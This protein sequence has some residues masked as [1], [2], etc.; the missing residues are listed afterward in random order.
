MVNGAIVVAGSR[1][2]RELAAVRQQRRDWGSGCMLLKELGEFGLIDRIARSLPAPPEDVLVGI[3]DDVA[4][5]GVSGTDYLLATCDSQ[6]ENVHFLRSAITPYR[7][8]RK[9]VAINV[10]DIASMG[11]DPSWALVSLV[12]PPDLPVDFVDELYRGSNDKVIL[13]IFDMR[14]QLVRKFEK[15]NV[16]QGFYTLYWDANDNGGQKIAKGMYFFKFSH[17]DKTDKGK[18]IILN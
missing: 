12:L 8:G 10:S 5:L 2:G 15:D 18:L 17:N 14:G 4:V 16:G 11:G 3:G 13:E 6:V 7:L 1:S 9:I